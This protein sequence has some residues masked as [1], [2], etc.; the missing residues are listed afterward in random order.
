M[1]NA[2][3]GAQVKEVIADEEEQFGRTLDR[4]IKRFEVIAAAA[5]EKGSKVIPGVDAFRERI[6]RVFTATYFPTD[7]LWC[8]AGTNGKCTPDEMEQDCTTPLA[9]RTT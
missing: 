1:D 6:C 5:L 3:G 4:G 2:A 9:F 8:T 7:A